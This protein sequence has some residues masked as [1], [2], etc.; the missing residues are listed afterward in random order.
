MEISRLI[1]HG[2]VGRSVRSVLD[3]TATI[4][5]ILAS[6]AVIV[7]AIT[8]WHATRQT[9]TQSEQTI[10]PPPPET[11]HPLDG[12]VILGNAAARVAIVQYSD[13]QCSFCG[14]FARETWPAI[15]KQYVESGKVLAAF[16]HLP[17][18]GHAFARGAAI[19][20]D[21]AGQQ[22]KFSQM[23]DRLFENQAQLNGDTGHVFASSMGLDMAT[24]DEC[25]RQHPTGDLSRDHNFAAMVG[26]R[27]TPTFLLGMVQSDKTVKVT[28]V[29]IGAQPLVRFTSVLDALLENGGKWSFRRF[30][31][32]RWQ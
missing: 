20:A 11:P 16:R 32:L 14:Q 23:H 9:V 29:L 15:R 17:L 2:E 28:N 22:G 6:A 1:S 10:G 30:R 26:I 19:S 24:F 12:A 7:L 25:V 31:L 3:V 8:N 5:V 21:C 4:M 27:G 13:F 18:P